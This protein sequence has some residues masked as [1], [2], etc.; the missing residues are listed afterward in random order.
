MY[1]FKKDMRLCSQKAIGELFET[2]KG[3]LAY[4]FSVRYTIAPCERGE[5]KVL[6]V[7]PKRYQHFSV[8]R[9]RAKRLMREAFRLNKSELEN[10]V[11]VQNIKLHFSVSLISKTIPDFALTNKKMSYI[12]SCITKQLLADNEH[13]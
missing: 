9:N 2:G 11:N 12:L 4:P 3:I 5:I 1:Q 6:I 10:I 13:N 7:S 8:N